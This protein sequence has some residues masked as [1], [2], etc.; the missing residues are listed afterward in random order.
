M[1]CISSPLAWRSHGSLC[2]YGCSALIITERRL[3]WY[4]WRAFLIVFVRRKQCTPFV[5]LRPWNHRYAKRIRPQLG[6]LGGWGGETTNG[7][8]RQYCTMPVSWE[9][10]LLRSHCQWDTPGLVS[11]L[12]GRLTII[13]LFCFHFSCYIVLFCPNST[14]TISD[15]HQGWRKSQAFWPKKMYIAAFTLSELWQ[16]FGLY[17]QT[18]FRAYLPRQTGKVVLFCHKLFL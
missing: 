3:L 2:I 8:K 11:T 7:T 15:S 18:V 4:C 16:I 12:V 14:L 10:P 5:M 17:G 1:G 6:S 13:N 9:F